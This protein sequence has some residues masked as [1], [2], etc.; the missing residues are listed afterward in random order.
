MIRNSKAH[1]I[2]ADSLN[3][4]TK[5]ITMLDK[6]TGISSGLSLHNLYPKM[7]DTNKIII[8][9]TNEPIHQDKIENL[10]KEQVNKEVKG[11]NK[12]ETKKKEKSENDIFQEC[13]LRV[14][15][16]IS[17]KNMENSNDIYTMKIDLG[18][19]TARDIGTGLRKYGVKEEEFLNKNVII[20]A[21][22]KPKKL[23][24]KVIF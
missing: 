6:Q 3:K 19:E 11:P 13:D 24:G 16:V 14:G 4:L 9:K 21:N 17:I 20:F 1:S 15:K 23:G 18:E 7:A 8:P 2:F 5:I 22:L 12:P 10:T